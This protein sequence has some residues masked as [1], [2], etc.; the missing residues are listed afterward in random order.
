LEILNTLTRRN[1]LYRVVKT[2]DPSLQLTVHPHL[3]RRIRRHVEVR[4]PQ[5]E[6]RFQ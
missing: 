5:L 3:R 4:A 6:G 2:P 1:L